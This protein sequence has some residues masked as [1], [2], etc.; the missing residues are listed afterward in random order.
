M[1]AKESAPQ[2]EDERKA[3]IARLE[4]HGETHVR[5]MLSMAQFPQQWEAVICEWLDAK[6]RAKEGGR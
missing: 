1:P 2:N 4:A 5:H 6:T 3:F